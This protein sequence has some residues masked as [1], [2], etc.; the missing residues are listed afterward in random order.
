MPVYVDTL[1]P[2]PRSKRWPFD[3]ACHLFADSL[4]ELHGFAA[5]IGLK[6]T[7]FQPASLPHYDLTSTRRRDAVTLGAI[8]LGRRAAVEKW[9]EI[10]AQMPRPPL[11]L[12]RVRV[13]PLLQ[14]QAHLVA[15]GVLAA[16]NSTYQSAYC[17]TVCIYASRAWLHDAPAPDGMAFGAIVAVADLVISLRADR[18][19][20]WAA[21]YQ[22]L[23][24]ERL[25]VGPW[26]WVLR[27]V[28]ALPSPVVCDERGERMWAPEA[29]EIGDVRRQIS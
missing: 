5:Q 21:E 2:T 3:A 4:D 19:D 9:R 7:W 8:E 18:A 26:V 25:I 24:Q 29:A 12:T 17:G 16:F 23:R 10:K 1:R 13:M 11:N 22:P 27:D 15:A 6:R 20:T 14:P 28:K